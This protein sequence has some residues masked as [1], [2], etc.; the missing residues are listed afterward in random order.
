MEKRQKSHNWKV[1]ESIMS[2]ESDLY[3]EI[4]HVINYFEE[5]L[6]I[7]MRKV[8]KHDHLTN[9]HQGWHTVIVIQI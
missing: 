5:Q 3:E 4:M 2:C 7:N 1:I 8:I 9:K 6:P